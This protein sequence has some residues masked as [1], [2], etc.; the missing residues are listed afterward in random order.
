MKPTLHRALLAALAGG[1]LLAASTVHAN[2]AYVD[3]TF[4]MF[5]PLPEATFGGSG[6]PNDNVAITELMLNG[7]D[8]TLGLSATPR[9][10]N[11]PLTNDGAGT[12]FATTG[13]NDGLVGS[14]FLGATWNFSFYAN[15]DG[16][17]FA[18]LSFDLL[19]DLDPGVD[20]AEAALGRLDLDEGITVLGGDPAMTSLVEGSQ[21]ANFGFL[22]AG[23]PS[24]YP[25]A[26]TPFDGN[27]E[28]E[29]SF[30]LKVSDNGSELGRAAINVNVNAVPEPVSIAL[31]GL[32]LAGIGWRRR[33]QDN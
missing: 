21:N 24:V 20:T 28:G 30:V 18:D 17:D 29:Y 31:M 12:F 1:G 22:A 25:P 2:G 33:R 16:G 15:I 13:I 5:G 7:F 19:Y 26:F 3:P 8:I 27:A 32:G 4:D 14:M 6:I 10:S 9:F 11:P 23:G